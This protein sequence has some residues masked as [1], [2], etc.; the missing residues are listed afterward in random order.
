MEKELEIGNVVIEKTQNHTM[1]VCEVAPAGIGCKWFE[2][3]VLKQAI[4]K[5]DDL[6]Y[7]RN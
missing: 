7:V 6:I 2:G 1:T 4:F 5:S 3:S